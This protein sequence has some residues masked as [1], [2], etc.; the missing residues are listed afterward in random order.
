LII[1]ARNH[2]GAGYPQY[3]IILSTASILSTILCISNCFLTILLHLLT[4]SVW[5]V[6]SRQLMGW[7]I[8]YLNYPWSK[9][10]DTSNSKDQWSPGLS[11]KFSMAR[12]T[13]STSDDL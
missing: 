3:R 2:L 9:R 12:L 13:I 4:E 1:I 6:T 5:D 8:L 7:Q 11:A 10:V